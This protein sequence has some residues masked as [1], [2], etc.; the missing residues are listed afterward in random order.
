[1][2]QC[3]I[4]TQ[5]AYIFHLSFHLDAFIHGI[6]DMLMPKSNGL[7]SLN[8]HAVND[9]IISIF[10]EGSREY[11]S[12][13]LVPTIHHLLKEHRQ[14]FLVSSFFIYVVHKKISPS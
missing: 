14:G 11:L 6:K 2:Q 5:K 7:A 4:G 9:N 8:M 1:M 12:I 3:N 13:A 10:S